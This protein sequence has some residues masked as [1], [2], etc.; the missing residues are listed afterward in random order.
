ME[1]LNKFKNALAAF[2]KTNNGGPDPNAF[3]K[4]GHRTMPTTWSIP[5][6]SDQDFY[7]GY[8][9]A[10]INK[11]ANR[12][13]TLGKNFL[14]TNANES[15]IKKANE[16]SVRIV[17]PY[18]KIIRDSVEFSERD[19]WYEISTYLDLEGI[20]YLMAV[21]TVTQTGLVGN[22]Q[23]FVLLNPYHVR[24]VVD[25][26]GNIGGYIE[27]HN[28]LQR[29]IPK[30]M[31][32]PI[33]LLNPFDQDK[34]FSLADAARDSQFTIKQANDFA[35]EAINGNLNAP[36]IL[37]SSIELPDDQFD[38]FVARV[39]N[40]GRGE[41]LFGNGAGTISWTDMQADLDKA[42]LDKINSINRD[43]LLAVSGTSKS[44]MGVEEAGA[45][46]EVSRT[47]KDDFTEN[48]VMPQVE[49]II[50]ALNLDYRKYYD[51][52]YKKFGYSIA[53][54][55]PLETDRDAEKADVEI[56]DAQ[57]TLLE[58]LLAA[59]YD[60][61]VASKYAKGLIDITDLGEA[62]EKEEPETDDTPSGDGEDPN[63]PDNNPNEDDPRIDED[64]EEDNSIKELEVYEGYP[65]PLV[66]YLGEL[67]DQITSL[68]EKSSILYLTNE[69]DK[70]RIKNIE[71]I[72]GSLIGVIDE[73]SYVKL[74]DFNQDANKEEILDTLNKRY[75]D[76]LVAVKHKGL[77]M[78]L[79]KDFYEKLTSGVCAVMESLI[80]KYQ[81]REW[82]ESTWNEYR[83]YVINSTIDDIKLPG[84]VFNKYLK[85]ISSEK[86]SQLIK[87][88]EPQHVHM[89][90]S[91][92]FDKQEQIDSSTSS[93]LNSIHSAENQLLSYYID[94]ISQGYLTP[95]A[96]TESFINGLTLPFAVWFTVMFPIFAS[97]RAISTSKQLN[98]NDMPLTVMTGEVKS[99]I[100]DFAIKEATSHINTIKSDVE[101]ALTIIRVQTSDPVEIKQML[102]T[103]FIDIQKRRA[104]LIASNASNRIFALSQYEAD[105]QVLTRS[106]LLGKAYKQLFSTTGDPCHICSYLIAQTNANPVPFEAPFASVGDSITSNGE[107]MKF[108]YEDI[109]A[110]NVHPN[111]NCSYR[112]I[113]KDDVENSAE[114]EKEEI[115]RQSKAISDSI[116]SEILPILEKINS[117]KDV[118][119]ETIKTLENMATRLDSKIEL[120]ESKLDQLDKRT[121]E[122]RQLKEELLEAN[123]LKIKLSEAEEYSRQ[124]ENI[125]DGQN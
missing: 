120:V 29:E 44:G 36:G 56:R 33:R 11:R 15:I 12:A 68:S 28:G 124:L 42:A 81:D 114:I 24:T 34:V 51:A 62:P 10:V 4:F 94:K 50:D 19:F 123:D 116:M 54:D 103:A 35:R 89:F 64:T 38:N 65:I 73:N 13:V 85:D 122:A 37:S 105:L 77:K 31:I 109:I 84:I 25:S 115:N 17:H 52:D 53:L 86:I 69:S 20:Y 74:G 97:Y 59:G 93:L 108:N 110:G 7:T 118:S 117:D 40:H 102:Q 47:Q 43:S 113:I 9:F 82:F 78:D 125:I 61:D 99:M 75:H 30:E 22:I 70:I 121:K 80:N 107:T 111:C 8:G 26:K 98:L 49:N 21:R 101:N 92:V 119:Q 23:K 55:N 27:Q 41:P 1:I 96:D 66:Q 87:I 67:A 3:L 95:H 91:A 83:D 76:Q 18:L 6:I 106:G 112:I 45:G 88:E 14:F 60:Y 16:D 5:E 72:D 48:A 63:Q 104:P 57:F 39:K 90:N 2:N 79:N 46:R 32:I 58:S 71:D 100:N